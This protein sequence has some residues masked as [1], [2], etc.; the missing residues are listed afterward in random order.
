MISRKNET[1]R[2]QF[3]F[4]FIKTH[5]SSV[6]LLISHHAQT[7]FMRLEKLKQ[8]WIGMNSTLL[9]LFTILKSK[10]TKN[11]SSL[12]LTITVY[13]TSLVLVWF[14]TSSCVIL[15]KIYDTKKY[16]YL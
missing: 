10:A 4:D 1:S 11:N 8:I 7:L 15:M 14:M 16:I 5:S 12:A 9:E 3:V 6:R 13:G 2:T